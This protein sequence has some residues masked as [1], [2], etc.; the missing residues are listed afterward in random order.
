MEFENRQGLRASHKQKVL[1][2]RQIAAHRV[3]KD[4]EQKQLGE[5]VGRSQEWISRVERGAL[6]L[7]AFE[8]A[9]IA[10]KLEIPGSVLETLAWNHMDE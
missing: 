10:A 8:Y 5:L 1:L 6:V 4:L 3:L 2:G 7:S 9:R